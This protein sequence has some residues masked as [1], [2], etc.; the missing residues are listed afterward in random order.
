MQKHI[1]ALQISRICGAHAALSTDHLNALFTAL[2]LHYEH[3]VGAFGANLLSTDIGS[4]DPYALLAG[5]CLGTT[6]C[7]H[8]WL[9]FLFPNS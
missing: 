8:V 3:G 4:S 9:T 7:Y 2:S 5:E 6:F 1:C